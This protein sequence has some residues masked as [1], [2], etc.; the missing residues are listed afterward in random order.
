MGVIPEMVDWSNQVSFETEILNVDSMPYPE[1]P[2][3]DIDIAKIQGRDIKKLKEERVK[4]EKQKRVSE[5]R[6]KYGLKPIEEKNNKEEEKHAVENKSPEKL[7]DLLHG[8]GL[9]KVGK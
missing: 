1:M 8:K 9:V 6:K 7:W 5:I 4:N 3:E 2:K